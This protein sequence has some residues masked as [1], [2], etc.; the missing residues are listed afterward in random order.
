MSAE[1]LERLSRAAGDDLANAVRPANALL[2]E[3]FIGRA[4]PA[5]PARPTGFDLVPGVRGLWGDALARGIGLADT[6]GKLRSLAGAVYPT[7]QSR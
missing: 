2:L 5:A 7:K 1:T 3:A 4:F 6:D